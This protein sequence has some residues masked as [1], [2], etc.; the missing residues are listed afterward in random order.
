MSGAWSVTLA[1]VGMKKTHE[2]LKNE[3]ASLRK[4]FVIFCISS[5]QT[6]VLFC[7]TVVVSLVFV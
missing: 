4:K 1:K 2:S 3:C 7:R 5:D 6:Y